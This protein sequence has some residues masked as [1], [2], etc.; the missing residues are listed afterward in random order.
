MIS[1]DDGDIYVVNVQFQ[2]V[3]VKKTKIIFF[4]VLMTDAGV[5]L[6]SSKYVRPSSLIM[7]LKDKFLILQN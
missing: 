7:L 5:R 4:R 2:Y 3:L 6:S 1:N